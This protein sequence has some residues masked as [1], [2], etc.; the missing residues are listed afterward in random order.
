MEDIR[1]CSVF[2]AKKIK[3]LW[4]ACGDMW[5]VN[6]TRRGTVSLMA[7]VLA[8]TVGRLPV[9]CVIVRAIYMSG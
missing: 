6:T 9:T 2:C 3:S 7:Q 5:V 4:I 1:L 8:Y